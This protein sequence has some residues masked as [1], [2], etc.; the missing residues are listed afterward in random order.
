[1][2]DGRFK[3][4]KGGEGEQNHDHGYFEVAVFFVVEKVTVLH[5]LTFNPHRR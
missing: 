4:Q 3:Q 5:E 1:M 2:A